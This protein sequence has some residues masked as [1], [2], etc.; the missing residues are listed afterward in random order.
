MNRSLLGF[1]LFCAFLALATAGVVWYVGPTLTGI[2]ASSEIRN[3]PYYLLQLLPA[4]A[5]RG[6][7]DASS[8]RSRFVTLAA[9]DQGRLLWQ[10]GAV[11]VVEGSVLVDVAG[12]QLLRFDRGTELVQM[13]TSSGYRALEAELSAPI[14]HLGSARP[15]EPLAADAATV[16]ALYRTGAET[17]GPA[18]LGVPGKS[19]WLALLPRYGGSV[20]WDAPIAAIRGPADW[21]RLLVLQFPRPERAD[22]WLEDPRTVTERAIAGTRVRNM[23]VLMAQPSSMGPRWNNR[24]VPNSSNSPRLGNVSAGISP[25]SR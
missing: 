1:L 21:N 23:M 25:I 7:E 5:L 6:S 8:W 3:N 11:Q 16:V 4:R 2:A 19:G 9:D 14:R 17:P 20:R 22:A 18:P 15:P 24:T 13:L 12:V 10:G